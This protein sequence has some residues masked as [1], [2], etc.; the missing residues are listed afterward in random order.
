MELD[1][2]MVAVG[3]PVFEKST[4]IGSSCHHLCCS[5]AIDLELLALYYW[6]MIGSCSA[7]SS[8]T[9]AG[10]TAPLLR[11]WEFRFRAI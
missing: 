7:R 2:V 3:Y 1:F 5:D 10:L 4:M 9:I 8:S 6:S 11:V